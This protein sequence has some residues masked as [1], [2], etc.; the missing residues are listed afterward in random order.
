MDNDFQCEIARHPDGRGFESDTRGFNQCVG[1]DKKSEKR[2]PVAKEM[3]QWLIKVRR[4]I[5]TTRDEKW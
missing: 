3:M 5:T 4:P 1:K 2:Q